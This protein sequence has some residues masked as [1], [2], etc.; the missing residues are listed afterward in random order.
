MATARYGDRPQV[1]VVQKASVDGP[2]WTSVK[3]QC[4]TCKCVKDHPCAKSPSG[5]APPVDVGQVAHSNVPAQS[6]F[7]FSQSVTIDFFLVGF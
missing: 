2:G 6:I 5:L 4:T 3:R 1:R 7:H